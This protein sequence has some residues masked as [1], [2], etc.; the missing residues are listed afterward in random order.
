M[1][2]RALRPI[3]LP[4]KRE[5]AMKSPV[6][7]RA[8]MV[9]R[10]VLTICIALTLWTDFGDNRARLLPWLY[11]WP[12]ITDGDIW[13]IWTPA[14][15]H[16]SAWG[17]PVFHILFNG[18]WWLML[19]GLVESTRGGF[20]LALFFLISA[21]LSNVAAYSAYGPFFGGLSG[22]VYA[23][24]GYV[25]LGGFVR[26]DYRAAVPHALMAFFTGF[27]LLGWTGLLGNMADFAHLGGLLTG[28]ALAVPLLLRDRERQS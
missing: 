15:L 1:H 17:S 7:A 8:G 27:M 3:F 22:V 21:G 28:M 11:V 14:F 12:A 9:T 25:W 2:Y 4:D 16:F 10:T 13:R 23:L 18:M 26:R 24:A 20:R 19:G 5:V 6:I